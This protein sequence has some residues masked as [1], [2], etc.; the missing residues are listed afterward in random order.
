V[1]EKKNPEHSPIG[2]R[3]KEARARMGISQKELGIR[4]GIDQFSA[5]ARINQ[6]ERDKHTPDYSTARR[7]AEA[8][9]VPVT[10]LYT[11]DNELAELIL[12]YMAA[13]K[14]L[15]AEVISKLSRPKSL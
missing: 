15:R 12:A 10:Y 6:Y 2:K 5:S 14:R 13:P 11:D 3:L 9:A 4:A 8:L 7:L 1:D